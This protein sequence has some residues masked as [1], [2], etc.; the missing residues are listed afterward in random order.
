MNVPGP[1]PVVEVELVVEFEDV[2]VLEETDVED[3]AELELETEELLLLVVVEG[4]T[5]GAIT[6]HPD[7]PTDS[8]YPSPVYP[9]GQEHSSVVSLEVQV[10]FWLHTE[11]V[12][13]HMS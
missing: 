5:V 7:P 13:E 9:D 3:E 4:S 1:V 10:A 8:R 11:S 6:V 12:D 2:D